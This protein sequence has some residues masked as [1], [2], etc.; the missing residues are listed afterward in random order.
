MALAANGILDYVEGAWDLVR[1]TDPVFRGRNGLI[2]MADELFVQ[3]RNVLLDVSRQLQSYLSDE[4]LESTVS[5]LKQIS[6]HL[7]LFANM[8]DLIAS[9]S[10]V[11]SLLATFENRLYS[12]EPGCSK[13]GYDNPGLVRNLN[14]DMKAEK[15]ESV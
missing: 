15:G 14:S 11:L 5:R 8:N 10:S 1:S 2:I 7:L 3:L 13:L 4:L 6:R 9:I 12:S